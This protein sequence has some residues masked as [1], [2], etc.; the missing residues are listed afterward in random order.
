[1]LQSAILGGPPLVIY[2]AIA[3][4]RVHTDEVVLRAAAGSGCLQLAADIGGT[5]GVHAPRKYRAVEGTWLLLVVATY[6]SIF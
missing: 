1:M 3:S 4:F 6:N 5:C 2:A